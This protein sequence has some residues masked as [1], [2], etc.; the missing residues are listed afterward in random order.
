M[1]KGDI[2][3][4]TACIGFARVLGQAGSIATMLGIS[5]CYRLRSAAGC[6]QGVVKATV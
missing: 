4:N 3:R 2:S 6:P 5:S 1:Q